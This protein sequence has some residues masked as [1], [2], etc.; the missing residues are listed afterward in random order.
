M[1]PKKSSVN[2]IGD[3]IVKA[4]F[5]VASMVSDVSFFLSGLSML[6]KVFLN[7]LL[8]YFKLFLLLSS[9]EVS[10]LYPFSAMHFVGNNH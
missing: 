3:G 1:K 7:V 4:Y 2:N 5:I 10:C 8:T 6:H 9:S